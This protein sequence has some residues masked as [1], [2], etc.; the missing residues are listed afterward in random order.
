MSLETRSE[1]THSSDMV[2]SSLY[3]LERARLTSKSISGVA[4]GTVGDMFV[5]N[6]LQAPMM[7]FTASPFIGPPVGPIVA[8]FINQYTNW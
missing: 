7:I 1:S 6:E 4:G 8:G 5:Q 3:L 2:Q